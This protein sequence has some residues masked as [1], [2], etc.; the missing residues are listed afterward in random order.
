M[1]TCLTLKEVRIE[2]LRCHLHTRW[3]CSPGINLI[4]G[5]NGCGK[6][7]LLEAVYL[8][9]HG[10]SFR[11]ARDPEL[12]R[13]GES[14]FRIVGK[15]Q[16]FGPLNVEVSGQRRKT[17]ISMQGKLVQKR[18]DLLETLPVLVDAPHARRLVDGAPVER[19][20]WLDGLIMACRQSVAGHYKRYFRSV[21]QRNRLLRRGIV[22]SEL[23]A[24]EHQLVSY[25]LEIVQER[26]GM[27]DEVN[28]C[29]AD[30]EELTDA[31]LCLGMQTTAPSEEKAWLDM[32]RAQRD[33]DARLGSLRRGPHCDRL[34]IDYLGKE[35]RSAGSRGQQKLAAMA[36]KLAEHS[37]RLRYR[38]I[39]PVMLMDDCLEAL[40]PGRRHRLL[41]R[42]EK[43]AAQVLLTAPN[44]ICL[45]KGVDIEVYELD[46]RRIK[47]NV[48]VP[49]YMNVEE[50]A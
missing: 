49:A 33:E 9:A 22:S 44:G 8:M 36:L 26:S 7:T 40:D 21:L 27:L 46:T 1:I 24:W 18:S 11:Q 10:R 6:T 4:V 17:E 30:E 16:R 38:S 47:S 48:L 42:L 23:D 20:H 43:S 5:E 39:A 35:I 19:R 28:A 41:A 50:A 3:A 34:R 31:C 15:W 13:W 45:P 14:K 12:V 32:L 25:G 29:L 2:A 37:L